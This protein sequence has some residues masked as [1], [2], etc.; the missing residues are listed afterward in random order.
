MRGAAFGDLGNDGF[1]DVAINYNDGAAVILRN[2]GGNGNHWL[3]VNTRGTASNRDGIG[4]QIRLVSESGRVQHGL[5][6]TAA[7]YMS[8]NDK[9]VH[10]GLGQDTTAKLFE[11]TWLSG[12]VQRLEKIPA[13]QIL[14][15]QEPEQEDNE[16]LE[17]RLELRLHE[18][19][20][21]RGENAAAADLAG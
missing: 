21:A 3:L 10:F 12:R 5:V 19:Q 11:I 18:W 1:M 7:S 13:D 14:A 4:A 8:A 2:Q 6:S 17:P 9:R 15:V 16:R 20:N